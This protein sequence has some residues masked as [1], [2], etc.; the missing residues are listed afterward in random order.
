M[1]HLEPFD[2][3]TSIVPLL[4]KSMVQVAAI[5][6]AEEHIQWDSMGWTSTEF[7]KAEAIQYVISFL[8]KLKCSVNYI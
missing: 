2:Q 6:P 8:L 3:S 7:Y 5:T 1:L 4:I